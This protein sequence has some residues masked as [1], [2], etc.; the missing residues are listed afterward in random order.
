MNNKNTQQTLYLNSRVSSNYDF[1]GFSANKIYSYTSI[2]RIPFLHKNVLLFGSQCRFCFYKLQL[3]YIIHI[4]LVTPNELVMFDGRNSQ[5]FT[6]L[7]AVQGPNILKW[8]N[9]YIL[10]LNKLSV[11]NHIVNLLQCFKVFSIW[12][13]Q[14][15]SLRESNSRLQS[16]KDP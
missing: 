13:P 1:H 7:R 11:H 9:Y 2:T 8:T 5:W 3:I 16:T 14:E 12:V 4:V 15:K 6:V 10:P